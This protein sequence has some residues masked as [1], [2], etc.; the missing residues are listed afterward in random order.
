MERIP[1]AS[2]YE[3]EP[4]DRTHFTYGG[5]EGLP[6]RCYAQLERDPTLVAMCERVLKPGWAFGKRAGDL[7]TQASD[8]AQRLHSD[9]PQYPTN[10]RRYGYAL[11]VYVALHDIPA[12]QAAVRVVPWCTA[13]FDAL[14]YRDEDRGRLLGFQVPLRQGELLIRDCRM[15]H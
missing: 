15:A 7:V 8:S 3:R 6:H 14:P 13:Q 10:S 4:Y 2:L 1:I 12:T 5:C 9:W 11:V